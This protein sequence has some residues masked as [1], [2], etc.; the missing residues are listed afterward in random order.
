[1]YPYLSNERIPEKLTEA[2]LQRRLSQKRS[3][4]KRFLR[5]PIPLPWLQSAAKLPGKALV[6]ALAIWYIDGFG[7]DDRSLCPSL[8]AQF[9]VER[10]AGYRGLKAL[11]RAGLVTVDRAVGRCPRVTIVRKVSTTEAAK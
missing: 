3:K 1:M 4:S 9:G 10:R 6:V 7:Q 8:L 5:G 2:S 11:E